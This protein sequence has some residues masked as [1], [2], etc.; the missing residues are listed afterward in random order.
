MSTT[1]ALIDAAIGLSEE[2]LCVDGWLTMC[3]RIVRR[4]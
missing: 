1:C 3:S 2:Y 4:Y